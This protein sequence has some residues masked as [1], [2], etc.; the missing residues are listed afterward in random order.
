MKRILFFAKVKLGLLTIINYTKENTT[1]GM[2]QVLNLLI[3][4]QKST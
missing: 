2:K 1:R 4:Q 3:A